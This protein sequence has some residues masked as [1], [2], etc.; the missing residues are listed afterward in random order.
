MSPSHS[1]KV[2]ALIIKEIET[3]MTIAAITMSATITMI[4]IYLKIQIE[5]RPQRTNASVLLYSLEAFLLIGEFQEVTALSIS[6]WERWNGRLQ[7]Q[8]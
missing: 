7:P 5:E 4:A 8:L 1:V 2:I 3:E 6:C